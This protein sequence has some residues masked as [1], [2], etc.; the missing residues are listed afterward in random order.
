MTLPAH[1]HAL[2]E[3]EARSRA[4]RRDRVA[5]LGW[6]LLIGCGLLI[7][8]RMLASVAVPLV[9]AALLA[10]LASGTAEALQRRRVP[11]V[12]AAA[13]LIFLPLGVAVIGALLAAPAVLAALHGALGDAARL[14]RPLAERKD[15]LGSLSHGLLDALALV[16]S[17]LVAGWGRIA[18]P[19]L[20]GLCAVAMLAFFLVLAQRSALAAF[21]AA[22]P[23][24]RERIALVGFLRAARRGVVR[25]FFLSAAINLGLAAATGM[26][27]AAI[28]LPAAAGWSA[29][30]FALLFIPYLGPL[31]IVLLLAAAGAASS[32]GALLPAGSFLALHALEA[33]FL[34]PW[35]MGRGLRVSRPM[36]LV[37]VQL[38]AFAWGVA[39]AMLSVPVLIVV[40]AAVRRLPGRY[41]KALLA[42]E[43]PEAPSLDASL[44]L[45]TMPLPAER[46]LPTTRTLSACASPSSPKLIRRK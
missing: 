14:G 7:A 5:R 44:S 35:V 32:S 17:E 10:L 13:G 37:S 22:L 11:S 43:R 20:L 26:A 27:L 2:A 45:S 15:A 19:G 46:M 16:D 8:L 42:A 21:I 41:A 29:V 12:L 23:S 9:C 25:W 33:N 6:R 4:T 36:L 30:T 18:L 28:G 1:V 40:H 31:A 3:P 34:S 24:R 38:G 39:G